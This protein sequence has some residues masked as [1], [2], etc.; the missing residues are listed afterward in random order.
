[1]HGNVWQWV[2][3]PY[4]H[5]YYHNSYDGA[6][7]DGSVWGKGG[8]ASSRV[9]RGGSWANFPQNLRSAH[10]NRTTTDFPY[11]VL[12]FPVG[13]TLTPSVLTPVTSRGTGQ[14][15]SLA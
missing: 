11:D 10:R 15:P 12:G 9:V 7:S 5:G 3:D 8:D 6:P 4:H 1:M 14:S 2:D 13:R